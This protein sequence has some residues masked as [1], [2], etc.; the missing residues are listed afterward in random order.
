MI[1]LNFFKGVI[2]LLG[3]IICLIGFVLGLALV[4]VILVPIT[5][6]ALIMFTGV[7]LCC[8]GDTGKS[9][10]K[11]EKFAKKIKSQIISEE[12]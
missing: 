9:E 5:L 8:L 6:I 11:M 4:L 7:G 3:I 2:E 10:S 12:E 1:I